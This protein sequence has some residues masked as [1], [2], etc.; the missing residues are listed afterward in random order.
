[1]SGVGIALA[2]AAI[3]MLVVGMRDRSPWLFPAKAVRIDAPC[4]D[5]GEPQPD[6]I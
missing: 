1:L 2:S 5:C 3:A 4:L 6:A